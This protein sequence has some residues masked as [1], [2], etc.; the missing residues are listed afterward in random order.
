MRKFGKDAPRFMTFQM[1]G[2]ETTYKLPLASSMPADELIALSEAETLGE[3]AAGRQQLS[4]LA[5]YMGE[6]AANS[7]NLADVRNIFVA[8]LEESKAMGASQ[9]E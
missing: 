5:K 9:G 6:E 7:L 8:W 4:I 2:D 1:E 3:V